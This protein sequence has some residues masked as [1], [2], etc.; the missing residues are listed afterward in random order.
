MPE[1]KAHTNS[2]GMK[3]VRIEAGTFNMGIDKT[4]LPSEI[5]DNTPLRKSW[6]PNERPYLQNG[7]FDEYPSNKVTISQP[8]Y[9]GTFEVTNIQY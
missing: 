3:F 9:M 1:G 4:P 6:K 5:T 2:V 8:F 7:D